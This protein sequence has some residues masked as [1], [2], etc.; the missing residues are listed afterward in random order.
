MMGKER[1]SEKFA[2]TFCERYFLRR[3]AHLLTGK[4]QY[5]LGDRLASPYFVLWI[6]TDLRSD[7]KPSNAAQ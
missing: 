2:H 1:S 6:E 7:N 3:N 5:R 4:P